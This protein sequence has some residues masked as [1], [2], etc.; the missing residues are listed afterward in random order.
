[1]KKRLVG[2]GRLT[3]LLL[4]WQLLS[5][6]SVSGQAG[7]PCVSGEVVIYYPRLYYLDKSSDQQTGQWFRESLKNV[8]EIYDVRNK[9]TIRNKDIREI[10]YYPDRLEISYKGSRSYLVLSFAEYP[11]SLQFFFG[12]PEGGNYVLFPS[13]ANFA[14][15]NQEE[16]AYFASLFY[17][18]QYSFIDKWR[19]KELT[20]FKERLA[21]VQPGQFRLPSK[22][23]S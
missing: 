15:A 22:H 23:N 20:A 11:D 4:L 1:M 7:Y 21:A 13:R 17:T 18:K 6:L 9:N 14:F 19:A 12:R 10:L 5:V 16:A 2:F 8:S 3:G